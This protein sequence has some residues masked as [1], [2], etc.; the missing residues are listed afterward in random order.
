MT[1]T[2][3]WHI[4]SLFGTHDDLKS[5]TGS[6]FSIGSGSVCHESSKQKV[7]AR[8]STKAEL[9]EIDDKS[10][11]VIWTKKFI[12][13]QGFQ[14]KL[15]LIYQDNQSTI[16]LAI[17]GEERSGKCTRLFDNKYFYITD[18]IKRNEVS[19]KFCQSDDMIADY[20]TKP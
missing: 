9:I 5:H 4:D 19:I 6:T 2:L 17:N 7:N 20:L 8:S 16:K 3:Y 15:N 14:I 18:L 11:K 1:Q 13:E 12:E 10:T